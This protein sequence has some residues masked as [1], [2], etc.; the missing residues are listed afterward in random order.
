MLLIKSG[1]FSELFHFLRNIRRSSHTI[2]MQF[3]LDPLAFS[4]VNELRKLYG[5]GV[6]NHIYYLIRTLAYYL[7]RRKQIILGS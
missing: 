2:Q 1:K 7:Y 3:L 6:I 4:E 5:Q